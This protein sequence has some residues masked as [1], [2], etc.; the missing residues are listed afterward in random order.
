MVRN[1][2]VPQH[3]PNLHASSAIGIVPAGM[4]DVISGYLVEA[5]AASPC[6]TLGGVL[7]G[8]DARVS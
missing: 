3:N 5:F 6:L 7:A 4:S 8:R 2:L 1:F